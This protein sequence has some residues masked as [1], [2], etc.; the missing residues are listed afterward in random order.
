MEEKNILQIE[1]YESSKKYS[2]IQSKLKAFGR[3]YETLLE[4]IDRSDKADIDELRSVETLM[5]RLQQEVNAFEKTKIDERCQFFQK[6]LMKFWEVTDSNN[7]EL[8]GVIFPYDHIHS[9]NKPTKR[10]SMLAHFYDK[11]HNRGY[12]AA[13]DTI[14]TDIDEGIWSTSLTFTEITEDEFRKIIFNNV[15]DVIEYRLW[16]IKQPKQSYH[17]IFDDGKNKDSLTIQA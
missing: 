7:G 15:E 11:T 17:I 6:L 13:I 16:K 14:H 1:S 9:F 2:L 4:T 5:N 3:L 10:F 12:S 8:I